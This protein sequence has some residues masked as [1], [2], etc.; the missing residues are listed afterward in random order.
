MTIAPEHCAPCIYSTL[1]VGLQRAY[2]C[3]SKQMAALD[4]MFAKRK[5]GA[6]GLRL[7]SSQ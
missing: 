3:V 6:A 7:R 2:R 1:D 4:K 5:G